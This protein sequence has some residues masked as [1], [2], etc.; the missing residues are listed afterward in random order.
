[1]ATRKTDRRSAIRRLEHL[2]IECVTPELDGGRHPVKRVVGDLVNVGADI[3]K[4]GHDLLA[5]QI[6]LRGP[7]DDD[8]SAASMT[9]DFDG[10][11]WYGAFAVDRV[12]KWSFSIEAWTDRFGTW[13]AALKKKVD[14]RQDVTVELAEGAQFARTASRAA[15]DKAVK[16][17]L[18]MTAKLLEDNVDTPFERRIQRALDEDLSSLMLEYL[19]PTDLTRFRRDCVIQVDRERA[20]FAAWY[21]MFPRSQTDF[22]HGEDPRHGTFN[23]AAARLPRIAE[24][25]FD[26]VYLPPIHPIGRTFRKGKNNSLAPDADDVGSPWAIGNED[27]GHTAIEPALG[28]LTDFDRFVEIAHGL[29]LEI[30]L[31]YALQCSPDHPWV[32]E[33]PDWFHIRPDG[34][35]QYA[36]NPPKKYQDIY[37]LNFW[38]DD[39]QALWDACR[40]VL[41]FWI[42][43][44]VKTFRVDNPH[45]KALAFW[46]WVIA[47]V[48]EEHPDAIFFA[49]AFTR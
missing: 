28:T 3:T 5:A 48:Q 32:K 4:E 12:G 6:I 1:M 15:K 36:E 13:R 24:L 10:D 29:N 35:I 20:Q 49:E 42:E 23:D 27:G 31:D 26:V 17:S 2:V 9:Y 33:H 14:A 38:C 25:G 34:S 46:E 21:E 39:R 18:V 37:P 22:V 11:R 44:G 47:E 16:A 45:T 7:G 40:D 19:R 41:L 43:H 30:A 8:W